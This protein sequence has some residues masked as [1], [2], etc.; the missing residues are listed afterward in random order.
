MVGCSGQK[1]RNHGETEEHRAI[2]HVR[3][4]AVR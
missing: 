1:W 2:D 4:G 3:W